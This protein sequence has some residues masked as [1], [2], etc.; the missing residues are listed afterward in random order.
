MTTIDEKTDIKSLDADTSMVIVRRQLTDDD[1]VRL[2]ELPIVIF[3]CQTVQNRVLKLDF[4]ELCDIYVCNLRQYDLS[5]CRNLAFAEDK[6]GDLNYIPSCS[7]GQMTPQISV[8]SDIN[9][10]RLTFKCSHR[11]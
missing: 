1:L 3:H 6:I 2:R 7:H 10:N 8:N 5:G 11:T 9:I 4:P